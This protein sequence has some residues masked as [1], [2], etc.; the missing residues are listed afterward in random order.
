M[1][2]TFASPKGALSALRAAVRAL[3]CS[4]STR[5]QPVLRRQPYACATIG[6]RGAFGRRDRHPRP[7][8]RGQDDAAAQCIA[9]L[10]PA[11]SGAIGLRRRGC[12]PPS[13]AR[14]RPSRAWIRAAGPGDLSAAHRGG[15]PA[16]SVSRPGRRA[17]PVPPRIFEMFPVLADNAAAG[18]AATSRADSSSSS[19]SV[20]RSAM[21]P[22][23]LV[24]DEP[25]EGDPAVDHQGHRARHPATRRGRRDGHPA[26]RA[27]L[28]LRAL[29]RGSLCGAFARRGDQGRQRR[30]H[31]SR[32]RARLP[33]RLSGVTAGW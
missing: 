28:R 9:G 4:P 2:L 12:H 11:R 17:R 24:L 19:P 14:A 6:V 30:G 22:K 33:D 20:A 21:E 31:G 10:L 1:S 13:T 16:S 29:A 23:L 7:Q 8:R 5:A 32:R 18:A 26:G 25:T 15:E 27:I 3:K